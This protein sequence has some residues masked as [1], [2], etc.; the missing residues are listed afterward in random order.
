MISICNGNKLILRSLMPMIRKKC[1]VFE[2]DQTDHKV[3]EKTWSSV[4]HQDYER[5]LTSRNTKTI[6]SNVKYMRRH[7]TLYCG[8]NSPF[9]MAFLYTFLFEVFRLFSS[10]C[11]IWFWCLFLFHAHI[12]FFASYI[13][14]SLYKFYY[15]I[16]NYQW[17]YT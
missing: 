13:Q 12:N 6:T 7:P 16:K 2:P 11:S 1:G 9:P 17:T 15:E 5:V 4:V 8:R 10:V 14:L 3:K